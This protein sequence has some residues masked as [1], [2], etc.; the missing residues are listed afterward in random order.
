MTKSVCTAD[1]YTCV[2]LLNLLFHFN[3]L[4]AVIITFAL[5]RNLSTRDLGEVTLFHFYIF[6]GIKVR[7]LCRSL[8]F[9]SQLSQCLHRTRF[10]HRGIAVLGQIQ[11]LLVQVTENC[12]YTEASF[13]ACDVMG[14]CP[15]T[16]G[17]IV[18]LLFSGKRE[19]S[20]I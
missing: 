2:C 11:A 18:Y 7:V 5:L 8:E 10:V 6:S 16:I 17:H 15:L 4:S 1:H 19:H 13:T 9:H 12:Y 14:R 3:S 20:G